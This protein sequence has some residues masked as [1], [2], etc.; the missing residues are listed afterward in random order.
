M[1]VTGANLSPQQK[2][3]ASASLSTKN[4]ISVGLNTALH[5]EKPMT[6]CLSSGADKIAFFLLYKILPSH[7]V[8]CYRQHFYPLLAIM[9]CISV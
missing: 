8:S 1:I 3:C 7:N 9:Q 2:A 6:D 4:L 5:G